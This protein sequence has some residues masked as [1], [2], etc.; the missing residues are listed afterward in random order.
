MLRRLETLTWKISQVCVLLFG[1]IVGV[2]AP[3]TT[4][5]PDLCVDIWLYCVMDDPATES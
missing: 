4:D 1:C 3:S 2:G 5:W